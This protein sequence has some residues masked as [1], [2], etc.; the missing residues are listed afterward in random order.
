M[1]KFPAWN[2]NVTTIVVQP[3]LV[4]MVA[5]VTKCVTSRKEDSSAHAHRD[6]LDTDANCKGPSFSH[7]LCKSPCTFHFTWKTPRTIH[8][9]LHSHHDSPPLYEPL[10]FDL[11]HHLF[12]II[13]LY[14]RIPAR[15]NSYAGDP[16]LVTASTLQGCCDIC[17]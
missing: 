6:T 8:L 13:Y 14:A 3:H 4:N 15:V 11:P 9:P 5:R 1:G 10:H 12:C 17:K 7:V 16:A 2:N